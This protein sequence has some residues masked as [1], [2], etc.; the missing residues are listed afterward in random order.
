MSITVII[1]D[2]HAIFRQGLVPL[3]EAE[4]GIE[5]VAQTANGKDAWQL[6][7]SLRPDVAILDISMP[8]V[9]GLDVARQAKAAKL[10]T[11]A[12]FS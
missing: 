6:I 5:L 3:L 9:T 10:D 2:D 12:S 4:S 7:Q 8:D 1:A 11:P